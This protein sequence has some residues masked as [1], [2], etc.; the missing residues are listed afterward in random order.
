MSTNDGAHEPDASTEPP[1]GDKLGHS[2]RA[3]VLGSMRQSKGLA[4][5]RV[6]C[7][8]LTTRWIV[9]NYDRWTQSQESTPWSDFVHARQWRHN[10]MFVNCREIVHEDNKLHCL[11]PSFTSRWKRF[12]SQQSS[13]PA[14]ILQELECCN[15][16]THHD[17]FILLYQLEMMIWTLIDSETNAANDHKNCQFA[18]LLT[19]RFGQSPIFWPTDKLSC[20]GQQISQWWK[21]NFEVSVQT[22]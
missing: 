9:H 1:Y 12:I 2:Y 4:A 10:C 8:W 13:R 17:V 19:F 21:L 16:M 18:I 22:R 20:W 5:S 14:M 3:R 11:A 15:S 7:N 6:R